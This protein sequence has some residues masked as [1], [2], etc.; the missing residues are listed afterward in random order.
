MFQWQEWLLKINTSCS[1]CE[2]LQDEVEGWKWLSG[3]SSV[4]MHGSIAPPVQNEPSL[5]LVSLL[6]DGPCCPQP[7]WRLLVCASVEEEQLP[8]KATPAAAQPDAAEHRRTPDGE[9]INKA[10]ITSSCQTLAF[11]LLLDSSSRCILITPI[12]TTSAKVDACFFGHHP[13]DTSR[14]IN[15]P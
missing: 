11:F 3:D 9:K 6:T 10:I 15:T 13:G 5:A 12:G 4:E 14:P 2:E 7:D 8:A 1:S